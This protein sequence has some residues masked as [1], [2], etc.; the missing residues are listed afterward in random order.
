MF[1]VARF[2]AEVPKKKLLGCI[3]LTNIIRILKKVL[4]LVFPYPVILLA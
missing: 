3:L 4:S 2:R 1:Y